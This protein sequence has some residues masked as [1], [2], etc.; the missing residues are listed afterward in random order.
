[1]NTNSYFQHLSSVN[2]L[3]FRERIEKK[4]QDADALLQGVVIAYFAVGILLA[5]FYN[6]WFL[7]LIVGGANLF[8]FLVIKYRTQSPDLLRTYFGV[9]LALFCVQFIFQLS[10]F[11]QMH[12]LLF[13]T[14]FLLVLLQS[15][16]FYLPYLLIVFAFYAVLSVGYY[17]SSGY[18]E[19]M[20]QIPE[21]K[22]INISL[23]LVPLAF[24]GG[25]S[26]L[27]AKAIKRSL[28]QTLYEQIALEEGLNVEANMQLA[29]DIANG[30]FETP[31]TLL[32]T[33]LLGQ[34]LIAMRNNLMELR[35]RDR[36]QKWKNSGIA[37]ISELLLSETDVN[38]LA[39]KVLREL[40][41]HLHAHQGAIYLNLDEGGSGILELNAAY[42]SNRRQRTDKVV[43]RPG[44]G[45]V[46]ET[47]LRREPRHLTDIPEQYAFISSGLG[48][49]KPENV[50]IVPLNLK[51]SVVGVIEIASF[52]RF[53]EDEKLFLYNVAENI[54]IAITSVMKV[55]ET[56]RL[57]D[58]TQQYIEQI[59]E[60]ENLVKQTIAE[61]GKLQK[62]L[63]DAER[64]MANR[65]QMFGTIGTLLRG[66]FYHTT[67]TE[68]TPRY[69][70]GSFE[71]VTGFPHTTFDGTLAT[72]IAPDERA[73][74][75]GTWHTPSDRTQRAT[76]HILD[77]EGKRVAVEDTFLVLQ[78]DAEEPIEHIG[79]IKIAT[80]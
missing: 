16:R 12:F 61:L 46:G 25:F 27:L 74:V 57:L 34:S 33:D 75:S 77:A 5:P 52:N 68:R 14:L 56:N 36:V 54:A 38:K 24:S 40:I 35:D 62:Q 4:L 22:M 49:A 1:M 10:G 29:Q 15:K 65:E 53:T 60:K 13:S 7:A 37:S 50:L 6:T 20:I 64:T 28:R 26:Y 43:I 18:V 47:F 31:Y 11:V 19:R 72:L 70:S 42:A 76:Y 23:F 69:L 3:R 67:G 63:N 21:N 58:E 17:T 30:E 45:L 32:E 41:R 55:G 9:G 51:D 2:S 80:V 59:L 79:F 44:E 48:E 78:E 39:S 66:F 71:K 73:D 8:F